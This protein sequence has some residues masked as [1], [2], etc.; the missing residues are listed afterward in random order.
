MQADPAI[1]ST[2]YDPD[3]SPER[4]LPVANVQFEPGRTLFVAK[5]W[6]GVAAYPF[7]TAISAALADAP[8]LT[9]SS[10]SPV[11]IVIFPG[12]YTEN[13]DLRS[14]VFL[15]S[16]TTHQNAVTING[17]V[18]WKPTGGE[19][20]DVV[21]LY[22]LNIE[23]DPDVDSTTTVDTRGKTAGQTTFILN[24]CFVDG[25][26]V[27]GRSASGDNRDFVFAA[28]SVPGPTYPFALDSCLFEWVAGRL[29]GMTFNDCR[30]RIIGSTAVPP[31]D[32]A[33]NTTVVGW[34]VTGTS[35]GICTGSNFTT[36]PFSDPNGLNAP[37]WILD[38]GA[39]VE[40]AGCSLPSLT[41]KEG[42][43]ADIRSSEC[44]VVQGDGVIYR[45]SLSM[46]V[47]PTA[48]GAN[49]VTFPVPYR[50]VGYYISLQLTRAGPPPPPPAS[51][52]PCP[53]VTNK[54]NRGFTIDD[55]VGGNTYDVIVIQD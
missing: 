9:P 41:V 17:T 7:Y 52:C 22:F 25:L 1:T 15:S 37:K 2:L 21:Q 44:L 3:A 5:S 27:T 55:P 36:D 30:F 31:K 24:G 20:K 10:D 19:K 4:R 51:P 6:P 46:R 14:W 32:P 43:T 40:F 33:V 29:K 45:R 47:G 49:R 12:K 11:A 42:A 16:A 53:A 13:I 35:K 39:S 28:T 26:M 8:G 34:S 48:A 18:T 23:G 38:P 54:T 50:S